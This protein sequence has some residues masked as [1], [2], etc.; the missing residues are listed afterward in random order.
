MEKK[1]DVYIVARDKAGNR[2]NSTMDGWSR[3][4][5]NNESDA[6]ATAIEKAKHWDSGY[7]SYEATNVKES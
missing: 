5:A 4:S 1:F 6:K 7:Y 3:I 2:V